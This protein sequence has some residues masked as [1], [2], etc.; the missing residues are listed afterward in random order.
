MAIARM[1]KCAVYE[2]TSTPVPISEYKATTPPSVVGFINKLKAMAATVARAAK[3]LAAKVLDQ[4]NVTGI[5]A[6][7][8]G[9]L[10][11]RNT[12]MNAVSAVTS[13]VAAAAAGIKNL[14]NDTIKGLQSMA[15]T[16]ANLVKLNPIYQMANTL[17]KGVD[18]S[19]IAADIASIQTR[20]NF[21]QVLDSILD[22]GL[23]DLF[24]QIK[25]CQ[26]IT[27]ES[28]AK[29]KAAVD[30]LCS[31]S[32]FMMLDALADTVDYNDISQVNRK[33]RK[34]ATYMEDSELNHTA[35]Y[36]IRAIM[37]WSEDF[38]ITVNDNDFQT[39]KL[40]DGEQ[41]KKMAPTVPN[42]L[43]SV[44]GKTKKSLLSTAMAHV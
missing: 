33:F 25:S 37:F 43:T 36:E 29:L 6:L 40:Y 32:N 20:I 9:V 38:M 23:H 44:L 4:L 41:I 10:A 1:S 16:L 21:D 30:K 14:V 27:P 28:K 7:L 12:I 42:Y 8:K 18:L 19:G 34:A 31:D 39:T 5:R 3:L 11:L 35:I 22:G 17:C 2:S 26:L 15:D 13:W 24:K